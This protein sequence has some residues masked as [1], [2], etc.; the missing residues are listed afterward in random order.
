VTLQLR[1]SLAVRGLDVELQ[2]AEGER[3]AILGPNGAGKSTLLAVVAGLLR[4]D[5]GRAELAGQVLFDLDARAGG[6]RRWTPPYGRGTALL[7]QDPLLFPHLSVLDNVAF[8]PRSAGQPT[9]S[10]RTTARRW[11]DEVGAA[12][13]ADRRPA[14]LSGGQAQRVAIARA[15]AAEPRLL[16]L[17]EPMAALDVAAAPTLRRVLRRVLAERSALIVTH[18][19]LDALLLAHRVVVLDGGRIVESG[20][21]QE[22]IAHPRTVFTARI[23]GLNLVRGTVEAR[24]VRRMSGE[25]FEGGTVGGDPEPVAPHTEAAAVFSPSAVA[26]YLDAPHGSPRNTLA[27]T[28]TELEPREHLVRVRADDRTGHTFT[29][30][31]TAASVGDLDLYPG[32]LVHF[33]VKA[34]AVTVYPS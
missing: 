29:A 3:V 22:V 10:A 20:P 26:V 1:A 8:G 17:D 16:L 25:L 24:G 23:A 18:D 27:V 13:F 21:T 7:A 32:R 28:I 12:E 11:L 30:D 9:R 14:Q 5:A 31:V 19:L 34:T 4:P 15:L 6:R 2:V 33:A